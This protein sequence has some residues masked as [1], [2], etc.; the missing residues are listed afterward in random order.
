MSISPG[1]RAQPIVSR[2]RFTSLW[3]RCLGER[4]DADG[5]AVY[6]ELVQYYSEPQRA[7][8]TPAHV[9]HCL[10]QLDLARAHVPDP[11]AV[12]MALWFHDAIYE[13]GAPDNELNSAELFL[14]RAGAEADAELCRKVYDLVLGTVHRGDPPADPD[15]QY[16]VDIDLSGF[17]LPWEDFRRDSE[18]V[19]EE[20][21]G[22]PDEEFFRGHVGFLRSLVERPRFYSTRFFRER[23]ETQARENIRRYIDELR[24]QGHV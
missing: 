8:H 18:A 23:Y 10:R 20:F 21:A 5:E 15:G 1:T 13:P 4:A 14:S 11:D 22:V 9:A 3:R 2:E 6:E 7:Y 19:R 16:V 12:E 17:G 24:A